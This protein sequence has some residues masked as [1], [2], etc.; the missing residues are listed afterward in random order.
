[1]L[2]EVI[3]KFFLVYMLMLFVRILGSWFP[4]YQGHSI[5]RFIAHY[6]DPYLNVF[7]RVIPPIGML[8]I[9]PIVGFFCLGIIEGILKSLVR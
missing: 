6:T 7:R 8:D 4:E 3:D 9:S 5:M 2:V 1:M